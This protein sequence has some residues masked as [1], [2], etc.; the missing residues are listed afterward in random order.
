[1]GGLFLSFVKFI[2]SIPAA[3]G[4]MFLLYHYKYLISLTITV[5][6]AFHLFKWNHIYGIK[7]IKAFIAIM[8]AFT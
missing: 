5:I 6:D 2:T 7:S 1:M 3:T 4:T 8:I